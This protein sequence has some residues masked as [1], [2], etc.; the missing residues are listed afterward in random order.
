MGFW[1]FDPSYGGRLSFFFSFSR[2]SRIFSSLAL[3]N[4]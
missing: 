1:V 3:A 4:C 2:S